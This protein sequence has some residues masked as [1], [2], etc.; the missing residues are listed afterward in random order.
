MDL[1]QL[2]IHQQVEEVEGELKLSVYSRYQEV[3][4]VFREVSIVVD[5][6]HGWNGIRTATNLASFPWQFNYRAFHKLL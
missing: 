4:E 6:Q 5:K 1:N 3:K 2:I